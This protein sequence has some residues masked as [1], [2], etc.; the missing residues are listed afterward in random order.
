MTTITRRVRYFTD[1]ELA[2]LRK[3]LDG[4]SASA[5]D[6]RQ[7]IEGLGPDLAAA[8]DQRLT[9]AEAAYSLLSEPVAIELYR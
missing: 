4:L 3:A 6:R 7:A 8:I 9:V 2:P 1:E 5:R